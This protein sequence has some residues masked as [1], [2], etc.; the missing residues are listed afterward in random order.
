MASNG[1]TKALPFGLQD[2]HGVV[3][4]SEEVDG[5]RVVSVRFLANPG[6]QVKTGGGNI[7]IASTLGNIPVPGFDGMK[8]GFN[9]YIVS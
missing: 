8:I 9:A 5:H 7:R 1:K 2:D 4:D 3:V 6:K